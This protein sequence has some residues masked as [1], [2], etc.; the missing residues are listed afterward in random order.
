[1]YSLFADFLSSVK[2]YVQ[3]GRATPSS[4]VALSRVAEVAPIAVFRLR[5]VEKS[6]TTLPSEFV[7]IIFY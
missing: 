6:A 3:V 2:K 5:V 7:M 1:M 4:S